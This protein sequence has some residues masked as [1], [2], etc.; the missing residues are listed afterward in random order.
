MRTIGCGPFTSL[1]ALVLALGSLTNLYAQSDTGRII[2]IVR[3]PSG[4]VVAGAQVTAQLAATTTQAQ[5]ITSS[6]GSYVFPSLAIGSYDLTINAA[7]FA[8]VVDKGVRV[9]SSVTTSADVSL[10]KLGGTTSIVNVNAAAETLDTTASSVGT[11]RTVEEISQLPLLLTQTQRSSVSFA[12][13]FPGVS[14]T[15]GLID[16]GSQGINVAEIN[17][18]P[19][20]GEGYLIDGIPASISGHG[21]LR[22]DFSPPPEMIEEMRLTSNTASEYSGWNSGVGVALVTKGGTNQFHGTAF[23]YLRNTV[24]D[25]KNYYASSVTPEQQNE[26]GFTIGGPIIKKK[27]YFF[28]M[29]SGYRLRLTP[30]GITQTVPTAAMRNGD[31][32]QLLGAQIGT[33]ALGRPIFQGEIYDPSTTRQGPGGQ[34][35]RDP[36]DFGAQL[37]HI[38]PARL[39][40]ISSFFQNGYPMP[41]QA[42]TQLNWT[43]QAASSPVNSD[44]FNIRI[45][46]NLGANQKIMF[47]YDHWWRSE[48]FGAPFAPI[49]SNTWILSDNTYRLRL[50]YDW[51]IKP[52][53]LL[54]VRA[55]ANKCHDILSEGGFP[56][57]TGGAKA[58]LTGVLQP[59]T[60]L[61]N[62][63]DAT[64][65]G[66]PYA[67]KIDEPA[68]LTP[69]FSDLSWVKGK[70][71]L[72][73][74]GQFTTNVFENIGTD[75]TGAGQYTFSRNETGLP[76]APAGTGWGYASFLI[77]EVDSATLSTPENQ[78]FESLAWGFYAQDSWR[79]TPKL[80]L[81]Y[82]LRWDIFVPEHE[83]RNEIASFDPTAV[84][85]AAGGNLGALTFWGKGAGRNG[86][87][88]AYRTYWREFSPRIGFAYNATPKTVIRGGYGLSSPGFFGVFT[89][90][91]ELP[92]YGWSATVT[93]T[94][95][96]NGVTP[97]FNW[98]QGFPTIPTV[99]NLN[100]SLLN[101]SNANYV[102][103]AVPKPG[104]TEN[105]NFGLQGEIP[106]GIVV[107]A[108]YVGNFSR[109]LPDNTFI[110][111]NQLDPK[112]LG[113][114][115]LLLQSVTSPAAITA[116]I[117]IP[118]PG[119]TGSV[120]QALRPYPQF[121][122]INQLSS[123]K[124]FV[125]YN[126]LQVT[127]QKHTGSGLSFL[128]AY[129]LSKQLT[130]ASTFNG[131]GH[132][133]TVVQYFKQAEGYKQL[134][135][136]DRPQMVQ[137]SAVYE[138][139]FGPG[140]R[141]LNEG[142]GAE[143]W[144]LGGW[145]VAMSGNYMAGT[146][147][148]LSTSQSLPGGYAAV[149]A[150]QVPG[151]P[152]KLESCS[153]FN[154]SDPNRDHYLNVQAFAD[155]APFTFGT[156]RVL[157][158][159]RTCGYVNENISLIKGFSITERV[160]AVFAV[161]FDNAFNRHSWIGLN[162]NIDNPS[163]FG[164]FGSVALGVNGA[165][166]I[167]GA[168]ATTPRNIQASLKINF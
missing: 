140:K 109:G 99:P 83:S 55:A 62:I 21:Q 127:V 41:T 143:R 132:G 43:G 162:A 166:A 20:G 77:G 53:L 37:N 38:D 101:G 149:F 79:V 13:T 42:G 98:N 86:L 65:F 75:S 28:G 23:E 105:V 24:L 136:L 46:Q 81:S 32:S 61:V 161:D 50:S 104:R 107:T 27:T 48:I 93:P 59:T 22:D 25:A 30:Q 9:I 106:L 3:D 121:I 113:L 15:P 159:V 118:Y 164:Q 114:G 49:I 44:K 102:N 94:S 19:E 78:R 58:G 35:I 92:N 57:A 133:D 160:K 111:L 147:V 84:N 45:D 91:N 89:S 18:A 168:G 131:Q 26:F 80:T 96:N 151:V 68:W 67:N 100:P 138:L 33:D 51:T 137:V 110:T 16:D 8:M 36:F 150:D 66:P 125:E 71:T 124:G 117:P 163:S 2:G 82:G 155:P 119:F 157:S 135:D 128:G 54:S 11:T 126:A 130:N 4:A 154:P 60:P 134:S 90:G 70:H 85:S 158:N 17:G 153:Q 123:P 103:P 145:Q 148:D 6:D 120:T 64:G 34:I 31:F 73:F 69:V 146:P 108:D 167:N 5:V 144:L 56:N 97:A 116:G 1:A 12:R 112:F 142:S 52:N 141:F 95:E 14:W 122:N 72:K 76:G 63:Q 139:P 165:G 152:V 74:G 47:A 87:V 39:S 115:S 10:N 88:E 7:G 156:T 129:T 40:S 29:Y